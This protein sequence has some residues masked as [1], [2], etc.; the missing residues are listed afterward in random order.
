MSGHIIA[1]GAREHNLKGIDAA[2]PSERSIIT[3][4]AAPFQGATPSQRVGG[5]T[6]V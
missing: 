2:R 4:G 5:P 1:K 6:H 3:V